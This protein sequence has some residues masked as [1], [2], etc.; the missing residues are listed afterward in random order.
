MCIILTDIPFAVSKFAFRM[1]VNHVEYACSCSDR[2]ASEYCSLFN[3][4]ARSRSVEIGEWCLSIVLPN[5]KHIIVSKTRFETLR[6]F[7]G[8]INPI[9]RWLICRIKGGSM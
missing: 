9:I 1:L 5:A 4:D 2:S 7:S 8:G 3:F 6:V